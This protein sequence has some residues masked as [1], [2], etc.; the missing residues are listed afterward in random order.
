MPNDLSKNLGS[1][2]VFFKEENALHYSTK[3]MV[4]NETVDLRI[5]KY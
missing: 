1:K 4:S 2:R 5:Q 3:C